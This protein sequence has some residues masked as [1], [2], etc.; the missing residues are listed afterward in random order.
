MAKPWLAAERLP[1]TAAGGPGSVEQVRARGASEAPLDGSAPASPPLGTPRHWR[2]RAGGAG[3]ARAASV[4]CRAGTKAAWHRSPGPDG[5]GDERLSCGWGE[6][7]GANSGRPAAAA[8]AAAP[9][10][11]CWQREVWASQLG[12]GYSWPGVPSRCASASAAQGLGLAAGE[13]SRAGAVCGAGEAGCR[14]RQPFPQLERRPEPR[15][16]GTAPPASVT[17]C[18][19]SRFSGK[20]DC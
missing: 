2:S 15:V 17:S 11:P 3:P 6:G 5:R 12:R 10:V 14:P 8:R 13:P 20:A 18:F 9:E 1:E 19:P 16:G 4:T 7:G